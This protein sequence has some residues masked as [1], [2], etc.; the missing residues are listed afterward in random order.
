MRTRRIR[1]EIWGPG[2]LLEEAAERAD[3]EVALPPGFSTSRPPGNSNLAPD[4]FTALYRVPHL[5]SV[6]PCGGYAHSEFCDPTWSLP[7]R[8]RDD[9]VLWKEADLPLEVRFT[10]TRDYPMAARSLLPVVAGGV[11]LWH[12]NVDCRPGNPARNHGWICIADRWRA[13]E[14]AMDIVERVAD[15]VTYRNIDDLDLPMGGEAEVTLLRPIHPCLVRWARSRRDWF[16]LEGEAV[17]PPT[18]DDGIEVL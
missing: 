15:I 4:H 18:A 6:D 1:N 3:L 8:H 9:G 10:F 17:G 12:P 13:D 7:S 2:G 14:R 5:R 16:P 11:V